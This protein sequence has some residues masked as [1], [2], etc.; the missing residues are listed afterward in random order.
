LDRYADKLWVTGIQYGSE[1]S[2]RAGRPSRG[3]GDRQPYP[4]E[5]DQGRVPRGELIP[6]TIL[7]I[8]TDVIE[9]T[10]TRSTGG[11]G[12]ALPVFRLRPGSSYARHDGT[13]ATLSGVVTDAAGM[14]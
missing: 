2:Q 1:G 7:G 4:E 5:A 11:A 13:A 14:R 8:P 3:D 12:S 9:G 6:H 10:Y